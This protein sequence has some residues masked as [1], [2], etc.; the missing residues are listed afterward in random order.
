MLALQ[1]TYMHICLDLPGHCPNITLNI[2]ENQ[3]WSCESN[4]LFNSCDEVLN[5]TQHRLCQS[6]SPHPHPNGRGLPALQLPPHNTTLSSHPRLKL[7]NPVWHPRFPFTKLKIN[8][9]L[10]IS[11][12]FFILKHGDLNVTDSEGGGGNII[13]ALIFQ[14]PTHI[15]TCFSQFV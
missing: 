7:P 10:V 2:K 12:A 4:A 13:L 5:V 15:K 9:E 14:K 3:P 1:R 11:N 6:I 8:D